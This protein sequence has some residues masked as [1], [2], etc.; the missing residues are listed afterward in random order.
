MRKLKQLTHLLDSLGVRNLL[1]RFFRLLSPLLSDT[2]RVR[3]RYFYWFRRLPNL[4]EPRLFNEK[5]I[6]RMFYDRN[7][8]FQTI[9]DEVAVRDYVKDRDLGH[10][11]AEQYLVTDDPGSIDFESL[12]N[13]FVLKPNHDSSMIRIVYQKR[14]E[15]WQE[16]VR[17]RNKWLRT[18]YS[19][20]NRECQYKNI[21]RQIIVE[22]FL[23]NG[24]ATPPE[25]KFHC[26]AGEA[27]LILAVTDRFSAQ[28]PGRLVR[29]GLAATRNR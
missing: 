21:Q 10:L 11:L 4:K 16:L 7:P 29:S 2:A 24:Q 12:P 6:W 1:R 15:D 28:A 19:R 26:F 27:K 14:E 17:L 8:L 23:G 18:D 13:R 9:S 5:M 20:V 25:Y 3:L 22:E